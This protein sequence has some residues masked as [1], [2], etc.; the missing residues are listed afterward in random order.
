MYLLLTLAMVLTPGSV[1]GKLFEILFN[2]ESFVRFLFH[3]LFPRFFKIQN[4]VAYV[5]TNK[6]MSLRV[7]NSKVSDLSALN[8]SKFYNSSIINEKFSF[9]N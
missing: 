3:F 1:I 9:K 8:N 2:S 6:S 5:V 4:E 7:G